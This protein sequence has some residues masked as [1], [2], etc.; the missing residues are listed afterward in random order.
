M[1]QGHCLVSPNG[2]FAF[3]LQDDGNAVVYDGKNNQPIF[4][5]GTSGKAVD[6]LD[7]QADGNLVLYG[8]NGEVLRATSKGKSPEGDAKGARLCMQ[9]DGNLCLYN[10]KVGYVW[11]SFHRA[12]MMQS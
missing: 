9:D 1:R 4:H 7:L 3:V 2:R 12:G 8:H 6:R 10:D 11:D 5:T